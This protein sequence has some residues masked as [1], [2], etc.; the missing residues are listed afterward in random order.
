MENIYSVL[1][2]V[3]TIIGGTSVWG[4][5]EKIWKDKEKNEHFRTQMIKSMILTLTKE[6]VNLSDKVEF[7]TK[8][9]ELLRENQ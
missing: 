9:N 5:Y 3:G 7:L 2:T 8:E 1:I 6:V 4:Y